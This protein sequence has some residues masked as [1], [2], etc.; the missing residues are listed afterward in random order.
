MGVRLDQLENVLSEKR[1]SQADLARRSGLSEHTIGRAVRNKEALSETSANKISRALGRGVESLN[2][3]SLETGLQDTKYRHMDPRR[4]RDAMAASG[5][6]P[7][8]LAKK[9]GLSVPTVSSLLRG[10]R[11]PQPQTIDKINRVLEADVGDCYPEG[12][13]EAVAGVEI[14]LRAGQTNAVVYPEHPEGTAQVA[15]SNGYDI[16]VEEG[17]RTHSKGPEGTAPTEQQTHQRLFDEA[18]SNERT[19]LEE[20][21]THVRQSRQMMAELLEHVTAIEKHVGSAITAVTE[22]RNGTG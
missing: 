20:L 12:A 11:T 1:W 4:L 17:Q 13:S 9:T 19:A 18:E 7:T 22:G 2:S 14:K 6:N 15:Q 8:E 10:L 5:M 21:Y 16:S 3:A